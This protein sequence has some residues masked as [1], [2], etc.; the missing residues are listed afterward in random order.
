MIKSNKEK[1][2]NGL[3][4]FI[5]Y[6][7]PGYMFALFMVQPGI[8]NA[9]TREFIAGLFLGSLL[10]IFIGVLVFYAWHWI[11]KMNYGIP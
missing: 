6:I 7:L 8:L 4:I 11:K 3:K 9:F 5:M 10:L 2:Q 1:L